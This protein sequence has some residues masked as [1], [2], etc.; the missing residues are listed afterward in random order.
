MQ[1]AKYAVDFDVRK[2][3]LN[4]VDAWIIQSKHA[5]ECKN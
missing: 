2:I 1:G 5:M 3:K 4:R